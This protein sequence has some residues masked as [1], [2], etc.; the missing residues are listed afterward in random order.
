MSNEYHLSIFEINMSRISISL[1]E[2]IAG[3]AGNLIAGYIQQD[4][5]SGIFTSGRILGTII[6]AF[7][8]ILFIAG[9]ESRGRHRRVQSIDQVSASP[10]TKINSLSESIYTRLRFLDTI[11]NDSD[12][13]ELETAAN[14]LV[15]FIEKIPQGSY[16]LV[17]IGE[18][19]RRPS[20]SFAYSYGGR[21]KNDA[22]PDMKEHS[23]NYRQQLRDA[24]DEIYALVDELLRLQ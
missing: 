1:L 11:G 14:D 21:T 3:I 23:R 20:I 7:A 2:L 16:F 5:W 12:A 4:L 17:K 10:N 9:I 22:S 24:R 8:M 19:T 13:D 18:L 6:G 15:R